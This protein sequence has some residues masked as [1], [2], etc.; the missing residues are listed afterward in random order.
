MTY[1]LPGFVVER[2]GD[3]NGAGHVLDGE[4]AAKGAAGDF[5]TDP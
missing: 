4:G 5:G 1:S 3:V 2:S